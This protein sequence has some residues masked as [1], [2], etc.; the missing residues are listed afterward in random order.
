MLTPY[1]WQEGMNN[2]V[3]YIQG[4]IERGA[5]VL[6]VSLDAGIIIFTYRRQSPKTFEIYDKLA[7][8]GLGQQ[9]DIEA[10]RTA[11]MEFAHRE[12]YSRSEQDVTI[13]RVVT[14]VSTPIKAAFNDFST[15]PALAISLFAELGT[16]PDKDQFYVMDF[17]GDYHLHRHTASLSGTEHPVL[18]LREDVPLNTNPEKA[19]Q[20]LATIWMHV[21]SNGGET[22]VSI[23][24]L[25]PEVLFMERNSVRENVFRQI[26]L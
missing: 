14:A 10:I 8:A 2:R 6:A 22:E 9:S 25:T 5:A 17:D 1:D 11:A 16:T 7:F 21:T 4:R 20:K 3:S 12:G 23:E 15:A 13:Q 24:G 19:A 18:S 26:E